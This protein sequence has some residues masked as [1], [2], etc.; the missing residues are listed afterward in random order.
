MKIGEKMAKK[1]KKIFQNP[2][3]YLE[4]LNWIENIINSHSYKKDGII[5][6]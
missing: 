5:L 6:V 3:E 2:I 4:L 1:H